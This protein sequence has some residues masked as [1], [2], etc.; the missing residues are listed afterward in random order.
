[1]WMFFSL[2]Y[3]MSSL[4]GRMGWRSIWLTAGTRPV[5]STRAFKVWYVKLDTPTDRTLL[6]G[7]LFTAFHVSLLGIELSMLTSSGSDAA[8]NKS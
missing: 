1:M 6:F 5:F 3:S 4:L 7:S 8:G 2:A